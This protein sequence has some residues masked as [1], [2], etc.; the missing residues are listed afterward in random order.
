ML[1]ISRSAANNPGGEL[2]K[3][4]VPQM[5]E[6]NTNGIRFDHA[7][8]NH[9]SIK[10][11][12]HFSLPSCRTCLC[13]ICLVQTAQCTFA[14]FDDDDGAGVMMVM[15]MPTMMVMG[16]TRKLITRL[17]RQSW[18]IWCLAALNLPCKGSHPQK[19]DVLLNLCV[20]HFSLTHHWSFLGKV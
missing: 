2:F 19:T 5:K 8:K 3:F 6:T 9:I 17:E 13:N 20:T 14:H 1:E 11:F 7:P 15:M 18:S 4:I 16:P 12:D 10:L